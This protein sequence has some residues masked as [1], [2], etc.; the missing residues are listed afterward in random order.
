MN[1]MN[2]QSG[3]PSGGS[4][5]SFLADVEQAAGSMEQRKQQFNEQFA[6]LDRRFKDLDKIKDAKERG[7]REAILTAELDKLHAAAKQEEEDLG[8]A[9]FGLNAHLEELGQE[10]VTLDSP[11]P[12]E[13]QMIADAEAGL[14]SAKNQWEIF[15]FRK[16]ATES[17]TKNL[18]AVRQKVSEMARAR[19]MK[20]DMKGSLQHIVALS[21]KVN[22]IIKGRIAVIGNQINLV[23]Q[24][25]REA[26]TIKEQATKA[27]TELDA[28]LD[29]IKD[30][31]RVAEELLLPMTD[32]NERAAQESK[33]SNLKTQF[34]NTKAERNA[35]F[36]VL[37]SKEKFLIALETAEQ[38]HINLRA[39]L[40]M[41]YQGL[42]S[43]T[44]ERVRI[45][46]ARLEA[47]K[48]HAD[49]LAAEKLDRI[50]A[51]TDQDSVEEMAK[52]GAAAERLAMKQIESMPQR[53]Q[54]MDTVR[55]AQIEA[56]AQIMERM[57]AALNKWKNKYGTNPMETEL[58]YDNVA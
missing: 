33:I 49:Q 47:K 32:P 14:E 8:N 34:E 56:Q 21:N 18:D 52:I 35:A 23:G 20:K 11:D 4:R 7:V 37:Q 2:T 1:A 3:Q 29:R 30:D 19:L 53:I 48:A 58:K 50:G 41:W 5:M 43:D 36:V 27:V 44:E 25:R 42:K 55:Q 39:S 51:K 15:G 31:M 6:S 12:L 28:T 46:E 22:S 54:D 10:Y 9:V 17:A 38:A 45:F 13:R 24:R 16:R 57:A 40:N 26:L